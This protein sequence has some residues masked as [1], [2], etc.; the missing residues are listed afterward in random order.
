MGEIEGS[1]A[2]VSEKARGIPA[3]RKGILKNNTKERDGRKGSKR[4]G[5]STIAS[6]FLSN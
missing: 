3:A 2:S 4:T 1:I 6:E 5:D